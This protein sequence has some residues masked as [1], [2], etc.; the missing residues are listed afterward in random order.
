LLPALAALRALR[1]KLI[2]PPVAGAIVS[3]QIESLDGMGL[4]REVLATTVDERVAYTA[5]AKAKKRFPNQKIVL[6]GQTISGA[7]IDP[8]T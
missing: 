5:L 1:D 8:A 6:R 3:F 7:R 4:P 2:S